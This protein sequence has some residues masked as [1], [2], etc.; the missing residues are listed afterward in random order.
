MSTEDLKLALAQSGLAAVLG[1]DDPP[2]LPGCQDNGCTSFL[3][4]GAGCSEKC[5]IKCYYYE[6][7]GGCV[8][9]CSEGSHCFQ[10]N[11]YSG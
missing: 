5:P 10:T 1:V 9:R 4:K 3:C 7:Q 8:N 11:C 2:G 6:C